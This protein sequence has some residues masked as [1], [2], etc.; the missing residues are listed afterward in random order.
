MSLVKVSRRHSLAQYGREFLRADA[1]AQFGEAEKFFRDHGHKSKK[2]LALARK[3]TPGRWP[4]VTWHSL[5]RRLKGKVETGDMY[6]SAS[7]SPMSGISSSSS[8]S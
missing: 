1:T 6:S 8:S 3:E 7:S 5:G 2:G 4:L